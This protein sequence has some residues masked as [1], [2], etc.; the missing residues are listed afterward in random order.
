MYISPTYSTKRINMWIYLYGIHLFTWRN[1]VL[2]NPVANVDMMDDWTFTSE[3]RQMCSRGVMCDIV[4]S[5]GSLV[6]PR[7]KRATDNESGRKPKTPLSL[8]NMD[9]FIC[10]G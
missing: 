3:P 9:T 8:G 5:R 7:D 10:Q 6:T 4:W 1:P 2:T